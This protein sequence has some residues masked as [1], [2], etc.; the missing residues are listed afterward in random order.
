[1]EE[2]LRWSGL[3]AQSGDSCVEIGSDPGDSSEALLKRG[4]RV[5]GIDPADM[6]EALK[7]HPYFRHIRARAKDLKRGTFS[8]FKWLTA[9]AS[10]APKYTLDTVEAILKHDKVRIEGMLLTLKLSDWKIADHIPEFHKRI[11]SWGYA[12]V[13]SRQLAFNRREICVAASGL[14]QPSRSAE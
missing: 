14:A 3:P 9:D 12:N 1:M 8:G 13:R 4:L 2:S 5:T 10:V 11:R 7:N 6:D